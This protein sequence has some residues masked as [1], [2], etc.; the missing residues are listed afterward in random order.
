MF[1]GLQGGALLTCDAMHY[2]TDSKIRLHAFRCLPGMSLLLYGEPG[3][4][5]ASSVLSMK[6][7]KRE[8]EG[9]QRY[10]LL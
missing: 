3:V 1:R 9:I 7:P 5:E 8:P 6:E 2:W 4:E 10:E